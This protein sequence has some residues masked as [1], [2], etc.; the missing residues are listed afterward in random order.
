MKV[1]KNNFQ[2]GRIQLPPV[3]LD[4]PSDLLS[5]KGALLLKS[6]VL[7]NNLIHFFHFR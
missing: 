1:I 3:I 6:P 2:T 4:C 5:N 7:E